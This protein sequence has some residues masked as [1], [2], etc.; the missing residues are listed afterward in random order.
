MNRFFVVVLLWCSPFAFA[1]SISEQV[2]EQTINRTLFILKEAYVYPNVAKQMESA[3]L[4]RI[5]QGEY[6]KIVDDGE[7]ATKLTDDLRAVSKDK[8]LR[9]QAVNAEQAPRGNNT[10][11]DVNPRDNYGFE[12]AEMRDNGIGYFKFNMFAN[13]WFARKEATKMLSKVKDAKAL[14]FDLRDNIGGSPRMIEFISSYLFDKPTK[15]NLFYD[16]NGH[17]VGQSLTF[18]DIPGKRFDNDLPVYVLTSSTTFS[19][20]EEFT[21]NLQSFGRATIVGETTGGGAHP[22]SPFDVNRHF[23]V[24]VPFRRAYNP[25]TKTNWEGVGVIP[26]IKTT[27]ADALSVAT[28]VALKKLGD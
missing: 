12:L 6:D 10:I 23:T 7:L 3:V 19:A 4:A 14:I 26:D 13:S 22:I 1:E 9:V 20:A 15:L 18:T 27:S 5:N 11:S 8:H 24:I 17:E 2:K 21:Y 25:I 16:R 28:R